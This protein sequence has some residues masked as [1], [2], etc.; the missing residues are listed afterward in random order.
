M[1]LK[2]T[3]PVSYTHLD[4]Y[5]RQM[6][7]YG[8]PGTGKTMLAKALANEADL[9]F[10]NT[11]GPD[12]LDARQM[13]Q[14]FERARHYAPAILFIDEAEVIGSRERGDFAIP[15]NQ[16][17]TELDGFSSHSGGCLL[18]TSRCV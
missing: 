1:A 9:P 18:Y 2:R 5:K 8:A 16:L 11:S 7:L 15:I 14:V 10:L 12:L 13:H 3:D 17:L 6:L 4:V